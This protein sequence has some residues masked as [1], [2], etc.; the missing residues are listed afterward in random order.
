M[1]QQWCAQRIAAGSEPGS[2]MWLTQGCRSDP[3]TY[4]HHVIPMQL[5]FFVKIPHPDNRCGH[6]HKDVYRQDWLAGHTVTHTGHVPQLLMM[7]PVYQTFPRFY[8]MMK[9]NTWPPVIVGTVQTTLSQ[10]PSR[11][12]WSWCNVKNLLI[13]LHNLSAFTVIAS[14]GRVL[15]I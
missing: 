8:H 1:Q 14:E 9:S 15:W 3:V 10:S 6:R 12:F 5:Y 2:L 7:S 13:S 4:I 11:G